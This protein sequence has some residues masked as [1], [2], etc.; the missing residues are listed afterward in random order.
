M[1]LYQN[2]TV[3]K[4]KAADVAFVFILSFD[5][6][7]KVFTKLKKYVILAL[8]IRIIEKPKGRNDNFEK[9]ISDDTDTVGTAEQCV[10]RQTVC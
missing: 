6:N 8:H 10:L 1:R 9:N 2:N 5:F 3:V 7:K 4:T